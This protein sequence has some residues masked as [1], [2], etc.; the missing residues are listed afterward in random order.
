MLEGKI[1][2]DS[3]WVWPKWPSSSAVEVSE[4]MLPWKIHHVIL[5]SSAVKNHKKGTGGEG[6]EKEHVNPVIECMIYSKVPRE[7]K[8][9]ADFTT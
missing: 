3:S 8:N 9:H 6:E 1:D 2:F 7:F 5:F 4:P